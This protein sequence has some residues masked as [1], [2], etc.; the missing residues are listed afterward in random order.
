MSKGLESLKVIKN[1]LKFYY[2]DE[3]NITRYP[4]DIETIEKELKSYE[5]EH[6]LRIRLENIN[7]KLVREK[8]E[9]EKKFKALEIIKKK[10]VFV[11][12]FIHRKDEIKDFE[13]TYEYYKTH[14]GYFH[15]GYKFDLL[16]KKE[17]TLL[18]E[19]L[20]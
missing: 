13:W 3:W 17:Y 1:E 18:K 10:N 11:W 6:A 19:V 12:G 9:N 5:M 7:Y 2:Q 15:S 4:K 8:Q 20:L 14:Y 16:T